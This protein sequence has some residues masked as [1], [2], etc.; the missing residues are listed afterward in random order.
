MFASGYDLQVLFSKPRTTRRRP[1]S[2]R[3]RL[4]FRVSSRRLPALSSIQGV[5]LSRKF[6]LIIPVPQ[7]SLA[8]SSDVSFAVRTQYSSASF[9]LSAFLIG[10]PFSRA[11]LD[12]LIAPSTL[13]YQIIFQEDL[14]RSHSLFAASVPGDQGWSLSEVPRR[15]ITRFFAWFRF[16]DCLYMSRLS[17]GL[18]LL[19]PDHPRPPSGHSRQLPI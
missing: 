17:L 16:L 11:H 9:R 2:P 14:H 8:R 12:F 19:C 6:C 4:R 7:A 18:H 5:S 13:G 15:C 1:C 10:F 3:F